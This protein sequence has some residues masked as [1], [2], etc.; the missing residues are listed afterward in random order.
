MENNVTSCTT[1]L[2]YNKIFAI[3]ASI[4]KF[5]RTKKVPNSPL[6][7]LPYFVNEVRTVQKTDVGSIRLAR[8]LPSPPKRYPLLKDVK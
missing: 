8:L 1:Y 4:P 5:T 6:T 2:F 3:V 7:P